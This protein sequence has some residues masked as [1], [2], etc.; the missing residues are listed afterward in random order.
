MVS[1]W[2]LR[3]AMFLF[4]RIVS[5]GKDPRFVSKENLE[6]SLQK[7]RFDGTRENP[8]KFG[9][10]FFLQFATVWTISLPVCFLNGDSNNISLRGLFCNSHSFF[11]ISHK[12]NDY[13]GWIIW[14]I[15]FLSE[16]ISD[17]Q[18]FSFR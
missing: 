12:A 1:V 7:Y 13:V 2:G 17:Q 3:L 4:V 18:K 8:I 10:W 5:I 11:W 15:G 9:I 16:A 6:N 14:A